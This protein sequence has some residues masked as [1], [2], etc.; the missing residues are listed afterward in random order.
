MLKQTARSALAIF[1]AWNVLEFVL[2]GVILKPTYLEMTE[3]WR[4][5][6]EWKYGV[7]QMVMA[8]SAIAFAL[9]YVRLIGNKSMP[10]A[11]SYGFLFGIMAGVVAGY[12]TYSVQPISHNVALTLFLAKLMKMTLAGLIVGLIVRPKRETPV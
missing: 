7:G 4:P 11:L 6:D 8:V 2:H 9:L 10:A 3:L 5:L 12:G 1:L